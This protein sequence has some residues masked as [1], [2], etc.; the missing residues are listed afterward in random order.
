MF[1]STKIDST[2]ITIIAVVA[3]SRLIPHWPNF[4]PVMAIALVGGATLSRRSLAIL[5][6]LL[7]MVLSDVAL[8]AVMGW[9]YALHGTQWAVY[10]AVAAIALMGR[11]FTDSSAVKTTFLGGTIAGVGFFLVTNFAV[12]L[13]GGFY[14]MTLEGLGMCYAAG[15]AFYRDGGNFLLNGIASTWLYVSLILG[16]LHVSTAVKHRRIA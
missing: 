1:K 13:A 4:T 16:M 15:L 11:L 14:P 2:I 10:G 9:E 12:W 8:G 6:P 5:V 3:L 7:A